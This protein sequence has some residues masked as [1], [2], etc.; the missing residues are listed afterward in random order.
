MIVRNPYKD[1]KNYCYFSHLSDGALEAISK[2][3]HIIEL[4]AGAEIIKENTRAD[5]FYLVSK[6][7]VE[8]LKRTKWG[9]LSKLSVVGYSECFGEMALLTGSSR[10]CSVVAKKNVTLLKLFKKDFE[11]IVRMDSTFSHILEHRIQNYAQYNQLRTLQPFALLP[12]NRMTALVNKLT[13]KRYASGETIIRQGDE[14]NEYFIIKSGKVAVI[15]K[16]LEDEPENVA[17]LEEGQ[18]FG[19]EA[20]ITNS[21]RSAT[22]QAINETVVWI[23]S[24][25]DF[26]HIM[27]SSFLDEIASED[28]LSNE[29]RQYVFLDVRMQME[30]DEEHILSA[31]NIPLDEL[32]RRYSELDPSKEYYVY[33]LIGARSATA[34]FLMNSQGLKA[35]SI[36]GGLLDW[37]GPIEEGTVGI[38]T[39]ITPT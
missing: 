7:Q 37:S 16:M 19:E 27:K 14:G 17:I 18:G 5:A 21:R 20:L 24:K 36:K 2:K 26:E 35:R 30:Y 1:L 25:S 31:V 39:R 33:C 12:P 9:Q 15:K 8:M 32:R 23:L 38:H 11:E 22:I 34:A 29:K 3:L 10:C 4:P 6:G 28:V 13:E